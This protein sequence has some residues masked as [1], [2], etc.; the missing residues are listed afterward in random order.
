M[1]EER[2]EN[3]TFDELQVGDAVSM[4][5]TLTWKD[6]ELF[7]AASGDL[8]PTHL[9]EDYA[10]KFAGGRITGHSLWSA[11]LISALLGNELPGP[12]TVYVAQDLRFEGALLLGDSAT[13]TV[14]V[15]EKRPEDRS[16]IL[17]CRSVNG[18]GET[19][20]T[21]VARVLAPREKVSLPRPPAWD[22]SVDRHAKLERFVERCGQL[23]DAVVAVAHPC[24]ESSL[25]AALDAARHS[26]LVPVLVGPEAKIRAVADSCGFDLKGVRIEDVPHSHAAAA[27]AVQLV[28]EG[29]A[30][31]LMKGS[32]HTDELMAE[33]VRG[34]AGLRT[35][36]RISHAFLM[37]VPTYHKPLLVTDA[38]INIAPDLITKRDIC[39][40][41]VDLAQ[42]LGVERPKV[43]VLAAVE[44]INPKMPATVDAA[45]LCKMADRGQITGAVLDGPLALDNAVSWKAAQIKQIDSEVAGDADILFV[46]DLEAGNIL[47]KQLTFLGHADAAGIVLGAR[48]PIVLTSRA[49]NLRTKLASCAVAVL[50]VSARQGLTLPGPGS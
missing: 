39:Q 50:M 43:A 38:A 5:R 10:R 44:T 36:R 33:V 28:R 22:V 19:L 21:G 37:D 3:R 14:S 31:V 18:R 13:V 30:A 8:N 2:L 7:A 9:D 49:D 20:M 29:E 32:L 17:D 42:I 15:R 4:T 48:V 16:V 41:A 45:C 12:G 23:P 25:G 24:D 46:P 1:A 11:A 34:E 35:E 26:L 47:A 40:N 27:R 6:V